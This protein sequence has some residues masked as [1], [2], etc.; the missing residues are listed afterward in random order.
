MSWECRKRK[1]SCG[2]LSRQA[3]DCS[4]RRQEGV[5]AKTHLPHCSTV[6]IA[7]AHADNAELQT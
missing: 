3:I 7:L 2:L 6:P 1:L 5:Q 4:L